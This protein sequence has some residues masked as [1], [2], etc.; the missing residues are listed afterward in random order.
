[1]NEE[2]IKAAITTLENAA[3]EKIAE[4]ASENEAAEVQRL[5]SVYT[6]LGVIRNT[7]EVN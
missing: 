2:Q 3:T 6:A 5:G 4:A 7:L 1:M